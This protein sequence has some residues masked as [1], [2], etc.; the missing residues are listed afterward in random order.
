MERAQPVELPFPA[1]IVLDMGESAQRERIG[2]SRG[3]GSIAALA[4]L[5]VI[6]LPVMF[7][8]SFGLSP[9]P[10]GPCNPNG[11]RDL[12]NAGLAVL[13]LAALVGLGVWRLTGW[14]ARRQAARGVDGG[15]QLEIALAAILL[16]A[17]A[18]VAAMVL[19]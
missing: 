16:L 2:G 6:G 10:D 5:V 9:C 13:V 3:C 18:G 17:G 7:V 1:C 14:W 4:V 11:G 19:F 8:F 15:R 12:R